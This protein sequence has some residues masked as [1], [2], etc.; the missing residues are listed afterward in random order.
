MINVAL[1]GGLIQD[2]GEHRQ[3]AP[4]EAATHVVEVEAGSHLAEAIGERVEVN[5]FHHQ[6]VDPERIGRGLKV[7]AFSDD[8]QRFIEGLESADGKILT[9]QWHPEDMTDRD[10]ARRLFRRLV[11]SAAARSPRLLLRLTGADSL[12]SRSGMLGQR[13]ADQS[14]GALVVPPDGLALGL[15]KLP[16][17][18]LP[19]PGI[20]FGEVGASLAQRLVAEDEAAARVVEDVERDLQLVAD[21]GQAG[22]RAGQLVSHRTRSS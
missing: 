10:W 5:T 11:E 7:S 17:R 18:V 19:A 13:F 9:V 22:G 8:G 20:G 15:L 3:D 1:D 2:V 16:D 12:V 4:R 21:P 14:P 6:V